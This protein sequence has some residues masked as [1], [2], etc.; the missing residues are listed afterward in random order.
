VG[1]LVLRR[2]GLFLPV[3]AGVVVCVFLLLHLVPGDPAHVLL[4]PEA[5][6]QAIQALRHQLGLDL[7]WSEQFARYVGQLLR[8]DLGRSITQDTSVA[9]LI[10]QRLPA[11][12]ELAVAAMTIAIVLGVALGALAA[13]RPNSTIDVICLV[14]AQFGVSVPVFWLGILLMF[15]F[16]VELQWL[17][18]IGRGPAIPQALADLL[19]GRPAPLA[20]SL[21]HL[22]MPAATL[23]LQGAA[24]I[25]RLVRASMIEA[26][27][28]DYI[29][30]ARAK[31]LRRMRVV[32]VHALANALPPAVTL[33]GWQFG[34][35]LGGAVLTES[36]FGWPGMGQLA[37]G[38]ISQR[39][40]PLVQGIALTL[41]LLFC[42]VN[43]AVD[44]IA[45]ALD[46][47]TTAA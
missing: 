46:P 32:M 7:P 41:A 36:I 42:A 9:G 14:F 35:L 34:N 11:T 4:G 24:L 23:G 45:A 30:T 22:A 40:L 44:L 17:P 5:S 26:L 27:A 12:L 47:R 16:A 28:S 25:C 20:A 38:A 6:P 39:D 13:T 2:V 21:A 18:A 33:I 1:S 8:G 10:A 29:R 15:A 43:L 19:A 37:V 31:G 3:L